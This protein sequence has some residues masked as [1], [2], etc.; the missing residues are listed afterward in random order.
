MARIRLAT[1]SSLLVLILLP[2]VAVATADGA[3]I[4][5]VLTQD[6][7]TVNYR[8]ELRENL[9]SLPQAK[10]LLD[11]SNSSAVAST[12]EAAIQKGVPGAR[13]DTS[14]FTFSAKTEL[15]D[16]AMSMWKLQVNITATVSGVM[17]NTGGSTNH[18]L[19]FLSMNISDPIRVAN[20]ELNQV[21]NTYLLQPLLSQPTDQTRYFL[22][23]ATYFNTFIPG[24]VTRRFNLLD[25]TWV[26]IVEVWGNSFDVFGSSSTWA[27]DPTASIRQAP[28]NLTVGLRPV[29]ATF[30]QFRVAVYNPTLQLTAPARARADGST[31]SFDIP[32]P[33]EQVMPLIIVSTLLVG[34]GSYL[35]ERKVT[36]GAAYKR[37]QR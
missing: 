16:V 11:A 7:L 6:S 13:L 14:Q 1:V 23:D 28:Y 33:A 15:V 21:G 4:D 30:L 18:R 20:L 22:N 19:D 12:I 10:V 34:L 24:Q 31:V 3:S 8:L 35:F 36:R 37:R 26:P 9:T 27:Y 32:T 5:I 29:E 25:F 17:S 2:L